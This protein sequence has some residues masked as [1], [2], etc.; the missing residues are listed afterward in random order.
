MESAAESQF[1]LGEAELNVS[2]LLVATSYENDKSFPATVS[3][4]VKVLQGKH[5]QQTD[6]NTGVCQTIL[7]SYDL[8]MDTCI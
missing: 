6:D 1:V 7:F 2:E 4:M 5:Q 8:F 3:D